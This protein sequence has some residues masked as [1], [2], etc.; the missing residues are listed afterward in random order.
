VK[1]CFAQVDGGIDLEKKKIKYD[2]I[3][4]VDLS[5]MLGIYV[6]TISKMNSLEFK[7]LNTGKKLKFQPN[8]QTN[9]GFGFNYKWLRLGIAFGLPFM[10]Q[11]DDKYGSTKR[12]DFQLNVFMRSLGID[13][14][15]QKYTGYYLNNADDYLDSTLKIYPNLSNM[16]VVSLGFSAYYFFNNK[17]FSYK[18]VYVRNQIQKKSAGAFILGGFFNLNTAYS[19]NGFVP[20][21]LP[22][23]I[24]DNYQLRGFETN[25]M[26]ISIGYTYTL[27]LFK[28][29][30]VNA[31]FVPGIGIRYSEILK[32]HETIT[33]EP[34]VSGSA[35]L[36]FSIGYEGKYLYSGIKAITSVNSYNYNT[37]DISSGTGNVQ[38]Y[39]GKRFNFNLRKKKRTTPE[40]DE[41]F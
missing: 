17:K 21:E 26:G 13:S 5:D 20:D 30:F 3:K 29:F 14:H 25:I 35:T 31:S 1:L 4:I 12:L 33:L 11:D 19:P 36:R 23:S 37:I 16:E 41:G 2:T 15:Y 8:G 7:D 40:C 28:R 34:V 18:A 24:K 38:L 27:V 6:N 39:I 9:L 10:N 22:D 32:K